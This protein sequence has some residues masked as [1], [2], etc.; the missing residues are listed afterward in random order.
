[1]WQFSQ[2]LHIRHLALIRDTEMTR[3]VNHY[4]HFSYVNFKAK[5]DKGQAMW[6]AVES[7]A[8]SIKKK[9]KAAP[10]PTAQADVDEY[11]FPRAKPRYSQFKGG[12][13]SPQD[14]LRASNPE[15][16][17]LTTFDPML[18]RLEGGGYSKSLRLCFAKI[19]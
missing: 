12:N 19:H 6:E 14:C 1:M 17:I 3:T 10:N 4:V 8:P 13:A 15:Q 11:G 18:V 16:N 9:S 5:V 2:P 7:L